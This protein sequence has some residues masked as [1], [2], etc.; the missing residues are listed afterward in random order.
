MNVGRARRIAPA[1]AIAA[2]ALAACSRC[3]GSVA[4]LLEK[5]G[6]VE[7]NEVGVTE[8]GDA[9]VGQ[10]FSIGEAVRTGASSTARLRV[11]A[12][13]GVRMQPSTVLRFLRD[14]PERAPDVRLEAGEVE[15]ESADA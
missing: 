13:G 8:W 3:G 15:L 14:R 1:V 6:T 12:R 2:L 5:S 4:E 10:M 11:G 9:P 7:R